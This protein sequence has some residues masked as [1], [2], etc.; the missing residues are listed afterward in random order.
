MTIEKTKATDVVS[1]GLTCNTKAGEAAQATGVFNI[2]C[3]DKDGNFKWEAESKNLVL[4]VRPLET[5]SV[6]LVFSMVMMTP[7]INSY[8]R[9]IRI[10]RRELN[11]KLLIYCGLI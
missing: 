2:I 5:V 7:L 11:L 10:V 8:K 1:S 4:Q 3:R 6:A 9:V